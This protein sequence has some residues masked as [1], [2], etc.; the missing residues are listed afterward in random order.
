MGAKLRWVAGRGRDGRQG[1]RAQRRRREGA[2]ADPY[3]LRRMLE[4]AEQPPRREAPGLIPGQLE[5]LAQLDGASVDQLWEG[6][7]LRVDAVVVS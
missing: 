7:G 6:N 3:L 5:E 2:R 1:S 4:S